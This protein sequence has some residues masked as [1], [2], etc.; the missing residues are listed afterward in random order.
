MVTNLQRVFWPEDNITKRDLLQYYADISQ[1]LL[2]HLIDRAMVMKRYP[3][4]AYGKFFFQK[5]APDPRPKW[6]PIC[7]I[8][9]PSANLV[10][11]PV[12]QSV[13]GLLWVVNLG[14]I[15]QGYPKTT[16]SRSS[17]RAQ[18]LEHPPVGGMGT[19]EN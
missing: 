19:I 5:R 3:D 1:F 9:H 14:C 11:F 4:G 10:D 8:L 12:I 7:E 2:P 17:W 13:A 15:V 18:P 6:I 16:G